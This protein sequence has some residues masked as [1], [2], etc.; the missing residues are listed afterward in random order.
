MSCIS[1]S[2]FTGA[3]GDGYCVMMP[4][5]QRKKTWFVLGYTGTKWQRRYLSPDVFDSKAIMLNHGT[6][7]LGERIYLK[8]HLVGKASMCSTYV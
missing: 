1:H 7:E 5:L 6:L 2:I 3:L 8:S 4:I